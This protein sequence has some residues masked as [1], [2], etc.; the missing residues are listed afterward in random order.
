M[1]K[2]KILYCFKL[3]EKSA[4][5]TKYEIDN[6]VEKYFTG[7]PHLVYHHQLDTKYPT[8]HSVAIENLDKVVHLKIHTFN[9]DPEKALATMNAYLILKRENA[10]KD[11]QRFNE[12]I[13]HLNKNI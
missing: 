4:T 6:Y 7:K 12:L 1:E 10:Y 9:P 13:I 2:S 5:L 8:N 3:D 11:Y